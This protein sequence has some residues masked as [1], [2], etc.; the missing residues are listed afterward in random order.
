MPRGKP[1]TP[2]EDQFILDNA[3]TMPG[4]DIVA[5]IGRPRQSV[6][7]RARALGVEISI[8]R[9]FHWWTTE[10][11]RQIIAGVKADKTSRQIAAEMGLTFAQVH[12]RRQTLREAGK[13]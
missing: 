1:F 8:T 6:Y 3:G 11:D 9:A 5:H 10:E 4:P 7:G 2:K 12:T 13:L